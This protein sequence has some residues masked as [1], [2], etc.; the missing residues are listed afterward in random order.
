MSVTKYNSMAQFYV[1]E[2]IDPRDHKVF[3]VGKGTGD[4]AY[5]HQKFQDGNKNPHKDRKIKKIIAIG[6][7]I[8]VNIVK[9]NL[10]EDQAYRLES[11]IIKKIGIDNLTNICEDRIPPSRKGWHPS[12]KTL[13]KRSAKLKG[14][15]RT[16]IWCERLSKAKQGKNNPRWGI[17]EDAISLESRRIQIIKGKNKPNYDLYKNAIKKMKM[18]S[19]AD[20]VS[21]ELGIGRGVCFRLKNKTHMIYEAFPELLNCS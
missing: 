17:K 6:K 2:L 12:A 4:R 5:Q 8:I 14:I 16:D 3:Y 19:S 15:P 10:N 13:A 20:T 1:Y 7:E 18:G 9:E 21:R 11:K